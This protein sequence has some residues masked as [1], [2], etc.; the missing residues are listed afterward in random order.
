MQMSAKRGTSADHWLGRDANFFSIEIIENF[1]QPKRFGYA[2]QPG[3][4]YMPLK[5]C[6]IG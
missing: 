2:L 5:S 1:N 3:R 4:A 6:K